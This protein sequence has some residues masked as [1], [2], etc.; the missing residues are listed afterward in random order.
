MELTSTAFEDGDTVPVRFTCKGDDLSPPLAWSDVPEGTTELRV[1]LTDPDA[2]GGTFVHWLV[3]GIDPSSAG[4]GQ[5]AVPPGGTQHE[6]G[7]GEA[8]YRGPCP[9]PGDSPHRYVFTVEAL[10]EIGVVLG[11]GELAA[12]FGR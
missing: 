8:N 7:F 9:P 11:S 1:S 12:S 6:N 3:T 10:D 4:V 5:G 2:P